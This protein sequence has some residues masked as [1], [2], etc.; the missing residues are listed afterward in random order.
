MRINNIYNVYIGDR[1]QISA[2]V[3]TTTR[4]IFGVAAGGA[5]VMNIIIRQSNKFIL[6]L[7]NGHLR[8]TSCI[9]RRIYCW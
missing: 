2:V 9:R 8:D 4:N 6:I 7:G 5:I 1:C 3:L